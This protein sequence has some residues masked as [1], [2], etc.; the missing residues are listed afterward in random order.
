MNLEK[1]KNFIINFVYLI[2]WVT[3]IYLI[4]KVAAIYL[5]PFLIG[6]IIAN[7]VQKPAVIVSKKIKIKKENCAAVFSVI[8]FFVV[9]FVIV[10]FC[11]LIYYQI[12]GFALNF[13]N[14]I[15][16]LK[17]YIEKTYKYFNNSLQY[18]D[19]NFL[20]TFNTLTSDTISN[21]IKKASVFLS[22][23]ATK[24]IKNLPNLLFCCVV[25]VVAT[26]YISKDYD[27]FIKFLNSFLS[28]NFCRQINNIKNMFFEC[29]LKL[30]IGYF[31]L[32]VITFFELV[33]G[34]FILG[35]DRFVILALLVSILDLLP[36][37]G[38]GTILI[39][40]GIFM[41]VQSNYKMG[42]GLI[43]L[44]L[45]IAILRN[46]FEPKIIGKQ[47][48]IN[49]L[50]TLLFIFL[51]FRLGGIFGMVILPISLTVLFKYYRQEL[52]GKD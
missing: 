30:T 22:N 28:K 45:I 44:Y 21:I 19:K 40:W 14:Q 10:L 38:T 51:G 12:S 31:W 35:I 4:F 18:F 6:I 48:D 23:G 17:V 39:P 2:C 13:S 16:G 41:F 9:I 50:F 8:I 47:I 29:F 46:Y 27:R 1:K 36:I 20:D 11:W 37:I 5:L 43:F 3:I 26:C 32:F 49:P 34:F 24:L 42:A 33:L 7:A 52:L 25:T 15:E